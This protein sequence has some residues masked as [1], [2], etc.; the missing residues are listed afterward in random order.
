MSMTRVLTRGLYAGAILFVVGAC[1]HAL[2]PLVPGLAPAYADHPE[3]FRP[4]P[5]WTRAYMLVHPF[6][7]GLVFA[8]AFGLARDAA[9]RHGRPLGPAGGAAFGLLVFL[10][11][12]LPTFLIVFAAARLPGIIFGAWLVQNLAQSVAAGAVLGC[13][14]DESSRATAADPPGPGPRLP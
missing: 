4:W 6:G 5:G 8:W 9:R 2:A 1:F 7:Y 3:F 13:S 11:G 12:S 10:V 14:R